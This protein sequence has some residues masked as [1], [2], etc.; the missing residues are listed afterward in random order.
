MKAWL[1]KGLCEESRA[2]VS[3]FDHGFLY[4]DGIYETLSVH[5]GK[6][7][8]L[9]EHLTRLRNSCWRIHLRLPW[10]A[11]WLA[12]AVRR[13]LSANKKPD[14]VLRIQVSRGP[15]PLG[16]DTKGCGSPTLV[17]F[18]R[19]FPI[20]PPAF[21]E[22][23]VK[24]AIVRTRRNHPLCLPPEAKSTNCL[25][26]ILAKEEAVRLGAFE[27]ILLNLSGFVT[28]GT[29][30]NVF[31]VRRGRLWTPSLDCGL[32]AGVTRGLIIRLARR[33]GLP[34]RE[35]RITASDLAR[36]DEIFLTNSLF[37]VMP[38]TRLRIPAARRVGD[39]R[40]GPVTRLL[41]G[42]YRQAMASFFNQR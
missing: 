29:V 13:T 11:P 30:S 32:L 34:V 6:P 17:I 7:I 16:F 5:D 36:S 41:V 24:A 19:P 20:Y 42:C 8:F 10:T 21:F 23:G 1:N 26:G 31:A 33:A 22:Q 39:G 25:N 37:G 15:G 4:G 28:E 35:G 14:S 2:R 27:G 40:V 3:V 38:V 18:Q 9:A 12:R